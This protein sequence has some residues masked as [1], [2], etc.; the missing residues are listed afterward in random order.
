LA[1]VT[2]AGK[3]ANSTN[4]KSAPLAGVELAQSLSA[5]GWTDGTRVPRGR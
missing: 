3:G 5:D 4:T 2:G 1:S